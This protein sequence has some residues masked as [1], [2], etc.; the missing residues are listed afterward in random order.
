MGW[1]RGR[2]HSPWVK[3]VKLLTCYEQ[4]GCQMKKL[5]LFISIMF[6]FFG[7][8]SPAIAPPTTALPG[9]RSYT[10]ESPID[11]YDILATWPI[12]GQEFCGHFE[13]E[14]IPGKII[15]A[16]LMFNPDESAE[17]VMGLVGMEADAS[18]APDGV[19]LIF[20]IVNAEGLM[21]T[22]LFRNNACVLIET[23]KLEEQPKIGI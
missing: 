13:V 7:C 10:C 19:I 5:F 17:W 16:C 12:P 18:G 6:F 21:N 3:S 23:S 2:V 1:Y 22:Y 20:S 9:G 11:P 15:F 8:A 14:E 4:R